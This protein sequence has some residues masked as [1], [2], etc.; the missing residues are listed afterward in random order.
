MK[1]SQIKKLLKQFRKDREEVLEATTIQAWRE[2]VTS[3][4]FW[5]YWSMA[6]IPSDDI[7]QVA[8]WVLT[9]DSKDEFWDICD[10]IKVVYNEPIK[11]IQNTDFS[12]RAMLERHGQPA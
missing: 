4:Y 12:I 2:W 5:F 9:K 11:W 8:E 1:T 10:T 6:N 3:P 7:A